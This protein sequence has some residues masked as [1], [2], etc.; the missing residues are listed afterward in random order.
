[1]TENKKDEIFKGVIIGVLTTSI[2][3]VLSYFLSG[4]NEK[5]ELINNIPKLDNKVTELTTQLEKSN[6]INAK[7]PI[8]EKIINDLDSDFTKEEINLKKIDVLERKLQELTLNYSKIGT[9]SSEV[10]NKVTA[11]D[12]IRNESQFIFAE[13]PKGSYVSA[14]AY[15][16]TSQDYCSFCN[17]GIQIKC[18]KIK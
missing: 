2:L 17:D 3:G 18:S 6:S 7:L 14:V 11:A 15:R 16:G 13:C 9:Y 8:L 12:A 4:I 5:L 1:M 10:G